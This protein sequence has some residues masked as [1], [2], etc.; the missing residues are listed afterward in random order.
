MSSSKG[1]LTTQQFAQKAGVSASTVSKWIRMEKIKGEKKGGKWFIPEAEISNISATSPQKDISE[2]VP[3]APQN[4]RDVAARSTTPKAGAK[5]Y[6]IREFSDLTYLTEYGVEKWLKEGRL[7]PAADG[8][9][10]LRVDASNLDHP[11]VKRLVR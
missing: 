11:A 7:T 8:A 6:S 4:K 1:F 2:K 3:A 5:S 10:R 9:G